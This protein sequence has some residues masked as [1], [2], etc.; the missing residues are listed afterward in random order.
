[1]TSLGLSSVLRHLGRER[2]RPSRCQASVSSTH[3]VRD[4]NQTNPTHN[5]NLHAANHVLSINFSLTAL[6]ALAQVKRG[7]RS[8]F[9][10]RK[11][12]KQPPQPEPT[13]SSNDEPTATTT[14]AAAAPVEAPTTS[15]R[16]IVEAEE[17][18]KTGSSLFPVRPHVK[19]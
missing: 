8:L 9:G 18:T 14:A 10:R 19:K 2:W 7:L 3:A 15:N 4:P 6:D 17:A 11:K 13:P 5:P 16:S 1:M 12:K